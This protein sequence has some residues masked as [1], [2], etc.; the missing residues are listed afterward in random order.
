MSSFYGFTCA[1]SVVRSRRT[2]ASHAIS[3]PCREWV[4][5]WRG[6]SHPRS[7]VGSLVERRWM[8]K[9]GPLRRVVTT[10]DFRAGLGRQGAQVVHTGA[11]GDGVG[12]STQ[13]IGQPELSQIDGINGE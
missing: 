1:D 10:D 5:A 6:C 3:S 7:G 2:R 8:A 4:T 9:R 11:G 12:D 13:L